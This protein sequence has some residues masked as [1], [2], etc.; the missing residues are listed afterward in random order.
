M[1]QRREVERYRRQVLLHLRNY[2]LR[3]EQLLVNKL[4]H[5][6]SI[7]DVRLA[8]PRDPMRLMMDSGEKEEDF[9]V[10]TFREASRPDCLFGYQAG[11]EP[12]DLTLN[13]PESRANIIRTNLE[14]EILAKG[15][16]LP[17]TCDQE[18]ITWIP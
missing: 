11:V 1:K 12:K 4:G 5:H 8:N 7:E 17:E 3:E 18:G 6:V 10:I 14:E 2:L 9:V 13:P 15:Y 16:G